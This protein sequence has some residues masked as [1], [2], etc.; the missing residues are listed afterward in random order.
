MAILLDNSKFG[1]KQ[2]ELLGYVINDYGT[3]PMQKKT[4]AIL[5]L[6]HPK[7]FNQLNTTHK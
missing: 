2:V 1:C 6:R 5:Q 3:T 7:T 4:E